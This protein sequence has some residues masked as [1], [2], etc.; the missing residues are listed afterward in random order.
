[1]HKLIRSTLCVAALLAC[2]HAGATP[3]ATDVVTALPGTDLTANPELDGFLLETQRADFSFGSGLELTS[4]FVESS[5]VS[6]FDGTIDF[7]WRVTSTFFS[8]EAVSAFHLGDFFAGSFDADWLSD[9]V[10]DVAPSAAK[11]FASNSNV[12]FLFGGESLIGGRS[13]YV[14]YLDTQATDYALSAFY[15]VSGAD[16]NSSATF[17]TFAPTVSAVPEPATW[18]VMLA[19]LA[20]V[21]GVMRRRGARA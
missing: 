13:S 1:M 4:G 21:G 17:A 10:G 20:G 16:G 5:V 14:F 8:G 19:G 2:A 18:A 6:A 7:Q 12:D 9:S 3:L 11:L 15:S